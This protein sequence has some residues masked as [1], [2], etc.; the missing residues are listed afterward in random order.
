MVGPS[1][2]RLLA[3]FVPVDDGLDV[4]AGLHVQPFALMFELSNLVVDLLGL[5][6]EAGEILCLAK[7]EIPLSASSIFG[8]RPD[9]PGDL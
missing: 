3:V 8:C 6:A 1:P 2:L 9:Q 7:I 5:R 4:V